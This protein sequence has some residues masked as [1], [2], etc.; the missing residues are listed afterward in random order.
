VEDGDSI[1]WW[2]SSGSTVG[3]I[4]FSATTKSGWDPACTALYAKDKTAEC[5]ACTSEYR[6]VMWDFPVPKKAALGEEF[7]AKGCGPRKYAVSV[8]VSGECL[9]CAWGCHFLAGAIAAAGLYLGVG[10]E[11][12]RRKGAGPGWRQ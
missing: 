8:S 6:G 1:G 10:M 4:G 2:Q 5:L 3:G 7:P 11:L 9:A 12:E